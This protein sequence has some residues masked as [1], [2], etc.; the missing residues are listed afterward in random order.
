MTCSGGKER[1]IEAGALGVNILTALLFQ[2]IEELAEKIAL[3]RDSR[4]KH[5]HDPEA[6]HVTLMMHT[7]V[8]ED[9]E[10]VRNQV[11]KPFTEYLKNSVD[12]WRQDSKNLDDLTE[13]EREDLLA[14]AFERY[15]QTSALFGTPDTCL[16]RVARL[17]EIGVN[18]I[19]CLID[20]GVDVDAVMTALYSLKS[21]KEQSNADVNPATSEDNQPP[22]QVI[23]SNEVDLENPEQLLTQLYQL[24]EQEVDSLLSKLLINNPR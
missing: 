8:G 4:A 11:Q 23:I 17:K 21:L 12:L 18:E 24:S 9:I 13:R 16:A 10:I 14:Y 19:A 22:G 3:Y 6:G 7:F 2:P 5:G 20:F 15:F 1:F